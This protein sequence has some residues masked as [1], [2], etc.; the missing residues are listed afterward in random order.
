MNFLSTWAGYAAQNQA[1]GVCSSHLCVSCCVRN[2]GL[3]RRVR[4]VLQATKLCLLAPKV[5]GQQ[6][7]AVCTSQSKNI[8]H[9]ILRNHATATH[10]RTERSSCCRRVFYAADWVQFRIR[11]RDALS[12]VPVRVLYAV[13]QKNGKTEFLFR[14]PEVETCANSLFLHA[15]YSPCWYLRRHPE[16]RIQI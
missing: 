13:Q 9:G 5:P 6:S 16:R 3:S 2:L 4:F 10:H 12:I 7:S 8:I 11:G 1:R 14:P 15:G